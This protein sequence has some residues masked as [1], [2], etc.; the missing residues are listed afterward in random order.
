L[1]YDGELYA[2]YVL[3]ECQGQGIGSALFNAFRQWLAA[4]GHASMLLWVLTENPA[5]VFYKAIGGAVLSE[6]EIEIGGAALM[7]TCYGWSSL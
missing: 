5:Q 1:K 4:I 2:V 7:E 3:Q 6:K